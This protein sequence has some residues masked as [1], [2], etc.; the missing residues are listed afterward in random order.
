[1][2]KHGRHPTDPEKCSLLMKHVKQ[3][4]AKRI[5]LHKSQQEDGFKGAVQEL[6][7]TLGS[8]SIVYRYVVESLLK[9][10]VDYVSVDCKAY[11]IWKPLMQ[12]LHSLSFWLSCSAGPS[13]TNS[14][15]S[16]QEG[17]TLMSLSI[18]LRT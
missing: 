4:D 10:E 8:P 14:R 17:R 15:R 13:P 16:G 7:D 1:M 6:E 12:H 9:E 11:K 18:S 5:V 2:D 3:K